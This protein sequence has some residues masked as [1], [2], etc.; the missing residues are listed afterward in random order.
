MVKKR[1]ST[2]AH[3][4]IPRLDPWVSELTESTTPRAKRHSPHA[5]ALQA[6]TT[7]MASIQRSAV[8]TLRRATRTLISQRSPL[9]TRFESSSSS[10]VHSQTPT[11]TQAPPVALAGIIRDEGPMP[12]IPTSR[13]EESNPDYEVAVDYRTS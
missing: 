9:L 3:P 7:L 11:D 2:E 8:H 10:P 6:R 1:E 12:A 4:S 13:M 5:F